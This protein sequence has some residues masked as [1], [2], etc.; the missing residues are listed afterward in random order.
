MGRKLEEDLSIALI[1]HTG[2]SCLDT[3]KRN[4]HLNLNCYLVQRRGKRHGQRERDESGVG[5]KKTEEDRDH[6]MAR[7]NT[8]VSKKAGD[9]TKRKEKLG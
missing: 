5:L 9:E 8:R 6:G 4:S 3:I 1:L 7:S 2:N